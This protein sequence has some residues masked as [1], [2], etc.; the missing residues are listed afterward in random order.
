[1]EVKAEENGLLILA[2]SY[3]ADYSSKHLFITDAHIDNPYC[4]R[5]LLFYHLKQ[6]KQRNAKIYFPG[7]LFCLMQG[8]YDPRGVKSDVRPEH[9]VSNYIDAV[10]EDTAN[11]L[12]PYASNIALIANGNHETGIM[13]RLEVDP[14]GRLVKILNDNGGKVSRGGYQGFIKWEFTHE[15]GGNKVAYWGYYHHG[16][17]GGPVSKGSQSVAR[18]SSILK[19]ADFVFSGHN[20]ECWIIRHSQY[21]TKRDGF[22]VIPQYHMCCGTYKQEFEK[23]DGWAIQQI[24]AP[25]A[26]GGVWLSFDYDSRPYDNRRVWPSFTMA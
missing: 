21:E 7:D 24:A 6:A 23:T 11:L 4:D 3:S 19:N 18:Y 25:K 9:N 13:K 17:Y 8:R 14:I 15:A 16:K 5:E 12:M 26:L 22:A 10:I 20:H 1:M 2:E